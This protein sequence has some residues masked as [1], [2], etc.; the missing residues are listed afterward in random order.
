MTRIG[1]GP[2]LQ[3]HGQGHRSEGEGVEGWLREAG[4]IVSSQGKPV[5]KGKVLTRGQREGDRRGQ[6][7]SSEGLCSLDQEVKLSSGFWKRGRTE[8][9]RAIHRAK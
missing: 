7:R 9:P 1:T 6:V 4:G 2:R 8:K 3:P 5:T